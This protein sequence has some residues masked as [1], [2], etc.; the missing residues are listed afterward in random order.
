MMNYWDTNYAAGQGGDFTFR[1]VMTSGDRL[2]PAGL[3]RLGW[4]EMTPAEADQITSQDKALDTPRPLDGAQG[5]FVQIDQPNV[6]LVTWKQ[7]E[8]GN[9]TVLRLVETSGQPGTVDVQIPHLDVKAAWSSDAMERK[10]GALATSAHGFSF[11]VK[12]YQIV[13][14]R[15]EGT[16][17]V[18]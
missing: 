3:S 7:A 18:K 16:G 12:P 10:Q 1:Y 15:V 2:Q 6:V 4:E 11:S 17:N 13:T 9:G 5:S 8:D 14:V